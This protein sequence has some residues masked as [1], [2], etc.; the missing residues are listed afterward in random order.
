MKTLIVAGVHQAEAEFGESVLE[1]YI[2]MYGL[3]DSVSIFNVSE[4][5]GSNPQD[6]QRE[7]QVHALV[8]QEIEK[9][10]PG[11]VLDIH[12]GFNAVDNPYYITLFHSFFNFKNFQEFDDFYHLLQK[13]GIK[14][15][16]VGEWK[17]PEIIM[18]NKDFKCIAIE[19]MLKTLSDQYFANKIEGQRHYNFLAAG[20]KKDK[21]YYKAITHTAKVVHFLHTEFPEKFPNLFTSQH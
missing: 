5:T 10:K 8:L 13:A 14:S 11:L 3:P 7:A 16:G 4:N 17:V 20:V 21:S 12:N 6:K 9:H 1:N 15:D 2:E 19:T 18:K